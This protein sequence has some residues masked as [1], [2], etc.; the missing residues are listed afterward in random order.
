MY[1][2]DPTMVPYYHRASWPVGRRVTVVLTGALCFLCLYT[3]IPRSAKGATWRDHRLASSF[4]C[5]SSD[6]DP[7]APDQTSAQSPSPTQPSPPP[8]YASPNTDPVDWSRFAYT[9][10]VTNTDYL[11]N[12]VMLFERLHALG[13]KADFL[14]MHPSRM[15]DKSEDGSDD[16]STDSRLLK[17]AS[18]EFGVKLKPVEMLH[19]GGRDCES[20]ILSRVGFGGSA[21]SCRGESAC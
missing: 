19:G 6:Q 10:Y 4:C 21:V 20:C 8:A 1:T 9:Q 15:Q 5:Q 16:N 17:K 3:L 2:K 14:I 7:T 11:C 18:E 13:A 12:S